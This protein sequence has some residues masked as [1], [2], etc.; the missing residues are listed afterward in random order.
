M[1]S[2]CFCLF[3]H[4]H[5]WTHEW[6]SSQSTNVHKQWYYALCLDKLWYI[7]ASRCDALPRFGWIRHIWLK[8]RF[9]GPSAKLNHLSLITSC[10][11]WNLDGP[12]WSR[13][14]RG[15]CII[16]KWRTDSYNDAENE[17]SRNDRIQ[18]I[19]ERV[20]HKST[21]VEKTSVAKNQAWKRRQL[22][23]FTPVVSSRGEQL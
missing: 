8:L 4:G 15:T 12:H 6:M 7:S 14:P 9:F 17:G 3:V 23:Y 18:K 1:H 11:S 22:V 16:V 19:N 2:Y 20:K 5:R 10:T 13:F 21:G